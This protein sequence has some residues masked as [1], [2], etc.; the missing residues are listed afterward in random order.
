[1][2]MRRRLVFD[3]TTCMGQPERHIDGFPQRTCWVL[4]GMDACSNEH[5][6]FGSGCVQVSVSGNVHV[7]LR[8]YHYDNPCS[9]NGNGGGRGIH[10]IDRGGKQSK[11]ANTGSN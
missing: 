6:G 8:F 4:L 5:P 10:T 3:D 9:D 7:V 1:M 2:L 11:Q